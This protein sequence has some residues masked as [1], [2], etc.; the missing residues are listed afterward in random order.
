[1]SESFSSSGILSRQG[2]ILNMSESF[3]SVEKL[4]ENPN[5][6]CSLYQAQRYGRKFVL[7][8][9]KT[10]YANQTVYQELLKKEFLIMNQLDHPNI[11]R[12]YSIEDVSDLGLCIVMEFIDGKPID[13]C[14]EKNILEILS[15]MQYIHARQIIHRDLKPSNILLTHNGNNVKVIDFGLSDTDDFAT[16]KQPAGTRKYA[17]PEQLAGDPIDNRTDIYAFGQVLQELGAKGKYRKIIAKCCQENPAQRYA[18]VGEIKQAIAHKSFWWIY[19]LLFILLV[20]LAFLW[21]QKRPTATPISNKT[22]TDTTQQSLPST[23]TFIPEK[24]QILQPETTQKTNHFPLDR[25]SLMDTLEYHYEQVYIDEIQRCIKNE[26]YRED[27]SEQIA[28]KCDNV[29]KNLLLQYHIT[30]Q[31]QT[32]ELKQFAESCHEALPI[33]YANRLQ[34]CQ[35]LV[36]LRQ[37]KSAQQKMAIIARQRAIEK[38]VDYYIYKTL[39]ATG[40]NKNNMQNTDIK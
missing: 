27:V 6:Y 16:L 9:L 4:K 23:S 21:L 35:T 33:K 31:R 26:D 40:I 15:A 30:S 36:S 24:V 18:N 11:I 32:Y 28:N 17:S 25:M 5:S 2:S 13:T 37:Q 19:V 22:V 3:T 1:M 38:A 12:V 29:L 10:E 14:T 8:V 34:Q 7:K 20:A 39:D